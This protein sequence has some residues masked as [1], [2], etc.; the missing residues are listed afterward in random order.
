MAQNGKLQVLIDSL[1]TNALDLSTVEAPIN[2]RYEFA[3][4]NG[5]TANKADKVFSDTRTINASSA[6]DLDLAGGLTDAFG[7]AITFVEVRAVIIKAA[8]ANTNDVVV[9]GDGTAP[10]AGM[11]ADGSDK[12]HVKPGGLFAWIAPDDGDGTVTATTADILQVANSSSGTSVSYDI[13][14]IGTSA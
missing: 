8:A 14:I 3:L 11:F 13:I 12:V 9:G 10:W 2:K 7:A 4:A 5:T 1:L 6:E